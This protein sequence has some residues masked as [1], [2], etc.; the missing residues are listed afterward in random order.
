MTLFEMP[1]GTRVSITTGQVNIEHTELQTKGAI[2]WD[3][4]Y[5]ATATDRFQVFQGKRRRLFI[6]ASITFPTG[7]REIWLEN[8]GPET[9]EPDF[10]WPQE[11]DQRAQSD[12]PP[13][14]EGERD[15][16]KN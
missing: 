4:T 12:H 5:E 6:D 11:I 2:A 3:V 1:A 14:T 15:E 16:P 8:D 10:E 13:A 9:D 7:D